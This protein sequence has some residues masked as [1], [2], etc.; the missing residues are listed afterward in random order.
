[1]KIAREQSQRGNKAF[2]DRMDPSFAAL[3]TLVE[4]VN[5]KQ[6][7]GFMNRTWDKYRHPATMYY[8]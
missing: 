2:L 4:E 5:R 3:R 7:R 1:M 8:S 6:N